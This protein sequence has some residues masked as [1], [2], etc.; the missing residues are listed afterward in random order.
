MMIMI[1]VIVII[2]IHCYPR[3]SCFS[4]EAAPD[5]VEESQ[6]RYNNDDN[7]SNNDDNDNDKTNKNIRQMMILNLMTLTMIL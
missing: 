6:P 5:D 1:I 7:D 3:Q 2:T 4:P